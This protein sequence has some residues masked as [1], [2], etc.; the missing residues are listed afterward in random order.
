MSG[1]T[2]RIKYRKKVSQYVVAV[3]IDLDI[4]GLVYRKWGGRQRAKRG[5]WLVDNHGDVYT[6]DAKAFAKTY[7][8][9]HPGLY[10]KTTPIWALVATTGGRIKTKE[11]ETGYKRNDYI[12]Y[13]GPASPA[14]YAITAAKFKSMYRVDK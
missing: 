2:K 11:G 6:V 8:Q 7:R 14:V 13:E 1:T 5:D 12:V 9:L 3:R 10:V 4:D